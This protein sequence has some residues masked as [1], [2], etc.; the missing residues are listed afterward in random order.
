ME[1][2]FCYSAVIIWKWWFDKCFHNRNLSIIIHSFIHTNTVFIY[3]YVVAF[4]WKFLNLNFVI[5]YENKRITHTLSIYLSLSLSLFLLNSFFPYFNRSLSHTQYGHLTHTLG[6]FHIHH[7]PEN[8]EP[9][10]T[11][12]NDGENFL[13]KTTISTIDW[14]KTKWK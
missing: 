12:Q 7:D 4:Y 10:Q 8:R 9:N 5:F 3:F 13:R 1:F 11:K 2:E 14:R 6:Y